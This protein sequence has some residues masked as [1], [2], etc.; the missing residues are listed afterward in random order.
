MTLQWQVLADTRG[1]VI[2]IAG[3]DCSI[4]VRGQNTISEA[5]PAEVPPL[6]QKTMAAQAER[7]AQRV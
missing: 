7:L 4:Q 2:C 3:F 5:P 1:T 6:V